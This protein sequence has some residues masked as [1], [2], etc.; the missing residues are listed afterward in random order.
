MSE[1]DNP[2]FIP[3]ENREAFEWGKIC[4]EDVEARAVWRNNR[5]KFYDE[6]LSHIN[7]GEEPSVVRGRFIREMLKPLV[8]KNTRD[9]RA[10]IYG[11]YIAKLANQ[12]KDKYSEFENGLFIYQNSNGCIGVM[13]S[14]L[15]KMKEAAM[16]GNGFASRCF[17]DCIWDI[18]RATEAIDA[19]E[20]AEKTRREAEINRA[21]RAA[22]TRQLRQSRNKQVKSDTYYTSR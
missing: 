11:F 9:F 8:V 17:G 3:E 14:A 12:N 18:S 21:N 19:A 13:E 20:A 16:D 22:V 2:R 7:D 15:K 4:S 6:M 10:D 1:S 5:E